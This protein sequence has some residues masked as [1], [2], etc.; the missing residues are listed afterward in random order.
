MSFRT[1]VLGSTFALSLCAATACAPGPQI[2]VLRGTVGETQGVVS[3]DSVKIVRPEQAKYTGAT[4]GYFIVRSE[5]DFAKLWKEAPNGAP[6]LPE[7]NFTRGMVIMATA[8]SPD[9]GR[10]QIRRVV[11]TATVL[12]V[13]ADEVLLGESCPK[14]TDVI[15][16]HE[17]VTTERLDKPVRFHVDVAGGDS[18]GAGPQPH[19]NCRVEKST[20]SNKKLEVPLGSV[21]ECEANVEATG[22]F[23]LMDHD[24]RFTSIPAGSA[25]KMTFHGDRESISFPADTFGRFIVRFDVRDDSGRRGSA[26]G[27]I[28]V[29]PPKTS[30]PFVQMAWSGFE[31]S[32]DPSTF[33]RVALTASHDGKECGVDA[34]PKPGWCDMKGQG[35]QTHLHVKGLRA[36][37]PVAVEYLDPRVDG[38]PFLCLRV[39]VMGKRTTEVCDRVARG[40]SAKWEPGLLNPQS[41]MFE[42]KPVEAA[43]AGAPAPSAPVKATKP[44]K[45]AAPAKK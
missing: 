29:P 9:I 2:T 4:P 24:W 21:V 42:E 28:D 25:T 7:V 40:A 12:H 15:R 38:G 8:E 23:A 36:K 30:D 45:P 27:E 34:K 13:Y 44:A 37:L 11:D 22:K 26:V 39:Y 41:G 1:L 6:P 43:D 31:A 33:P 10:I 19:V 20:T 14:G 17:I 35:Y 3:G 18:C 32:D 5:E 16:A